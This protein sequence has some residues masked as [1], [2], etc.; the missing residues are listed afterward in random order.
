VVEALGPTFATYDAAEVT[1]ALRATGELFSRLE[2]EV[3]DHFDL[4]PPVDRAEILRR[5][6]VTLP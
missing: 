1:R 2:D 6:D 3:A 4:T 5:L